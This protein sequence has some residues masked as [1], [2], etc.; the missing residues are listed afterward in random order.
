MRTNIFVSLEIFMQYCNEICVIPFIDCLHISN[1]SIVDNWLLSLASYSCVFANLLI[2][3]SSWSMSL[4][5]GEPTQYP[6]NCDKFS[7][8]K[9]SSSMLS[10]T[11][12][13]PPLWQCHHK[14]LMVVP[15]QYRAWMWNSYMSTSLQSYLKNLL[16][17]QKHKFNHNFCHNINYITHVSH[18]TIEVI[19]IISNKHVLTF[20][21][22]QFGSLVHGLL[23]W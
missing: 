19:W 15:S 13:V 3:S 18:T 20:F 16:R 21:L 9:R 17:K 10:L 12:H 23:W 1:R 6:Y 14:Y 8:A 4:L 2:G 5:I 22:K 7:Y 11:K